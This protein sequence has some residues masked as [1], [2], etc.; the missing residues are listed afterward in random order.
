MAVKLPSL[1]PAVG[2]LGCNFIGWIFKSKLGN[3]IQV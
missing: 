3:K 2:R 1:I